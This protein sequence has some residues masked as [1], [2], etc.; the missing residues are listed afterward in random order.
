V[1][2]CGQLA[3]GVDAQA[4]ALITTCDAAQHLGL[5]DRG[6]LQA[7]AWADVVVLDAA[8][9]LQQVW[10]EGEAVPLSTD[11]NARLG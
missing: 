4:F 8:L 1:G 10:V 3:A 5:A 9:Q 7:G 2:G 6:Q 11:D